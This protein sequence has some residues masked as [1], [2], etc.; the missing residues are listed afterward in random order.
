M[1]R[2]RDAL[3]RKNQP[4]VELSERVILKDDLRA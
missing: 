3:P 2:W 4:D 1:W